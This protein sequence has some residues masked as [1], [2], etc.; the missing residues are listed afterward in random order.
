[1]PIPCLHALPVYTCSIKHRLS[2]QKSSPETLSPAGQGAGPSIQ[3]LSGT[4]PVHQ[5]KC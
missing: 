3:S 1:L 4:T 5:L 2:I